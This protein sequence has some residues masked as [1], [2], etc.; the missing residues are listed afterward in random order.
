MTVE[1][2]D[3]GMGTIAPDGGAVMC[4]DDCQQGPI[5]VPY[6]GGRVVELAGSA[7]PGQR[8]QISDETAELVAEPTDER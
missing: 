7:C 3:D 4:T 5:V 6:D 2:A 1:F 8:L